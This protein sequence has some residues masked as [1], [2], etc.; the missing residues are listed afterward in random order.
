[1]TTTGNTP[2]SATLEQLEAVLDVCGADPRRWPEPLRSGLLKLVATDAAAERLMHE[3]SALDKVLSQAPGLS[4]ARCAAL[5]DRIAAA[6]AAE[7][8]ARQTGAGAAVASPSARAP[9]G[10]PSVGNVVPLRQRRQRPPRGFF[11]RDGVLASAALA[12]SLL[13][14]VMLGQSQ[15]LSSAANYF[16][17]NSDIEMASNEVAREQLALFDDADLILDEDLL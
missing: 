16:A 12:A 9:V 6:A 15:L 10:T 17:P 8:R 3:A 7:P 13:L 5:A 11:E 1:M 14:G 2:M 4:A